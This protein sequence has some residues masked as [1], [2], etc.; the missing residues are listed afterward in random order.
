[1][2]KGDKW[3]KKCALY[4]WVHNSV[5]RNILAKIKGSN[6]VL[7]CSNQKG[8][9]VLVVLSYHVHVRA[10]NVKLLTTAVKMDNLADKV[11]ECPLNRGH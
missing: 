10:Y 9:V 11:D 2:F 7:S 5:T 8:Y 6:A 4:Y 3:V 1:M